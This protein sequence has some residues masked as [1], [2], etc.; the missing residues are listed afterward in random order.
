MRLALGASRGRLAWLTILEAGALAIIAVVV[1]LPLAWV[2][3][4]LCKTHV[5]PSVIRFIPGYAYV[6]IS[7]AVFAAMALTAAVAALLASLMPAVQAGRAAVAQT[8][9]QGAR[10]VTSS[11]Q[12]QWVRSALATAQ[13]AL[14][15]ALLFGSG[16]LLT[17][18]RRA[19][20]G[21]FGFDKHNVLIGRVVLPERPYA[22]AEQRRQ[23]VDTVLDRLRTIPAVS[24]AAMVS[25]LP[26]AGGNAVRQFWPEGA[27]LSRADVRVVDYRQISGEYFETMHIPLLSGRTFNPSDRG[28]SRPVAVVSRRLADRYWPGQ[29]ALGRRFRLSADG[30]WITVVGVVGRRPGRLV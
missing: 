9:R 23:F 26:Y 5:P 15:L 19:V 14:T 17:T 18:A 7:P 13:I 30:E 6:T 12:R 2:G 20:D 21:T 1:A 3:I 28:E 27:T 29:D 10:P 16:L 24:R 8:L 25:M 11:R 4:T 22:Q